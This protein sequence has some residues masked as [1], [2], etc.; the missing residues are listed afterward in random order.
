MKQFIFIFFLFSPVFLFSQGV[1]VNAGFLI[2]QPTAQIIITSNGNWTNNA[3][4]TCNTGSWVRMSGNAIQTIQGANTT[5]FSNADI[6]SSSSVFVGRDITVN[7]NLQLTAGYFD[8]RGAITYLGNTSGNVTGGETETKRI[9]ATT[10]AGGTDDGIGIG[11]MRTTR[12]DPTGNVANLGLNFTPAVALGSTVLIRGHLRQQGVGS[13]SSNYSVYR[14]YDIQPTTP[15]NI[16]VNNFYYFD[17]ELGSQAAFEANLEMFQWINTGVFDTW[18][19]R[20]KTGFNTVTNYVASN[21]STNI[22]TTYKITLASTDKPLPIELLSF[23]GEC[24]NDYN[25]LIWQTASE[26]NNDY[27]TLEKSADGEN[28]SMFTQVPSQGNSSIIQSYSATDYTPFN[29]TNYYRLK[30]TDFDG[31]YAYSESISLSC[32]SNN[33]NEDI[34]PISPSGGK[35]DVIVQGISGNTYQIKLTNVLGQVI[36]NKE[37]TLSNEQQLIRIYARNLAIGIY[38]LIMQTENKNI[39]KPLII[40]N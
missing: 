23:K 18:Q 19:P 28:F 39:S 26:H 37:I 11:T 21:T 9:R 15:S 24:N 25:N 34:L 36:T 38:Y 40:S 22:L 5:V 31:Q 7:D 4:A 13:F 29:G 16:T 10:N 2:L 8:L 35:V 20:P 17:A 14:Y 27:F 1:V 30:Q 32:N 6:N 33:Y 12:T 3:T